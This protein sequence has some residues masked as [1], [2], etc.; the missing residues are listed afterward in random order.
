MTEEQRSLEDAYWREKFGH[1]PS[2]AEMRAGVASRRAAFQKSAALGVS[3]WADNPGTPSSE[4][5]ASN[6]NDS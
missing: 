6:N 2:N 1:G 4:G 3:P 5:A